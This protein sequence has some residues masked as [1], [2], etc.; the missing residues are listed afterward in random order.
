[1]V[2]AHSFEKE[3]K[4]T[5]GLFGLWPLGQGGTCYLFAQ[6]QMGRKCFFLILIIHL[7]TVIRWLIK[8][9]IF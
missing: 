1:M 5:Q 2:N 3:K 7:Q 6:T 4:P 8:A 9:C